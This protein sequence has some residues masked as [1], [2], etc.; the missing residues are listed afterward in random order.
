MGL[1]GASELES[2]V[3]FLKII[4]SYKK[5][6]VDMVVGVPKAVSLT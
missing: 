5:F 3:V 6:G 2:V 4:P 1:D